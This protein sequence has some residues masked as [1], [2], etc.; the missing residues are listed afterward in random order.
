[1]QEPSGQNF[2]E[3]DRVPSPGGWVA[4][5]GE[6]AGWNWLPPGGDATP[7]EW[8]MPALVRI[9]ART[10]VVSRFANV[11]IWRHGYFWVTPP[12]IEPPDDD[13]GVREPRR[14]MAPASAGAIALELVPEPE[15][16]QE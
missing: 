13:A 8:E 1:M 10:P 6:R 2:D 16:E 5:E 9:W 12:L 11:W 7:R 15:Q 14:P 4:P 3:L